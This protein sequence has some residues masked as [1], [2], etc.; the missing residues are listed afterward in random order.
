MSL[1]LTRLM[2]RN[3]DMVS[4]KV[5]LTTHFQYQALEPSK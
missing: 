4:E 1:Y 3:L 2:L 5:Y